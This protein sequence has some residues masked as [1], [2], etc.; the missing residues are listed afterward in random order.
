MTPRSY[1]SPESFKQALEQRLR[2]S[3]A[4]SAEFPRRRQLL[5]FVRST[6]ALPRQVPAPAEAW[7][8]PYGAMAREDELAWATLDDVT[9]AARAFLDPVLAGELEATWMPAE[10]RWA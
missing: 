2:A 3:A 9:A 10:W 4:T 1:S 7:R 5:V 8:T 6:H